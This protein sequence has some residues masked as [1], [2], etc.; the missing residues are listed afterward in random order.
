M[1]RVCV[2]SVRLELVAQHPHVVTPI[3]LAFD[4]RGRLLV[5]ES[6]THQRPEDYSGP[7]SDRIRMLEN[8]LANGQEPRWSTW[9]A[10]FQQAMNL[11]PRSQDEVLLV[12]RRDVLWIADFDRDGRQDPPQQVLRLETEAEYPHNGLSGITQTDRGELWIGLGENFGFPYRLVGSDGTTCQGRGG[13]GTIFTC[14]PRGERL[15]RF[16]TGFWNPFGLTTNPQGQL[17]AVDNDPDAS[18]PCRL[19]HVVATGDYGHRYEYGRSG[20]HPLQAWNGELPGTLPMVCGTGEAPSAVVAHRGWLWVA[21][22]GDHR[23]ERYRL[24][25]RGASYSAALETV[26]QG[27]HNFRPTG[28]TVGP[29][30]SIFFGDWVSA[31]YP[32]H[33]KGRIWR[34]TVPAEPIRATGANHSS[35][36]GRESAQAVMIPVRDVFQDQDQIRHL[37]ES[38]DLP[39]SFARAKDPHERSQVLQALRWRGPAETPP[40]DLLRAALGDDDPS[41]R[42]LAVRWI[43]DERILPLRQD[44]AQLLDGSMPGP[45]YYLAVLAAIDWLAREPTPRHVGIADGLLARELRHPRRSEAARALALSLLAPDHPFLSTDRLKAYFA[46]DSPAIRREAVRAAAMRSDGPTLDLLAER[47]RDPHEDV[48]IR[49]DAIA[50]LAAAPTHF[51]D[52]LHQLA[53]ASDSVIAQEAKRVL[54]QAGLKPTPHESKPAPDDL[55]AWIQLTNTPG[56]AASGRRLFFSPAGTRCC[57]C[58][59]HGRRGGRVGPDLTQIALAQD[60]SRILESILMPGR[61]IAPQY[62][63]WTLVTQDGRAHLGLRLHGGG[64]DQQERYLDTQGR[65]FALACKAIETREPAPGSVMPSG[66]ERILTI[67]D[68]R[69]LLAFLLQPP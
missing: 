63:A 51:A 12:T 67:A 8:P 52:L 64:D 4:R 2:E 21:S 41:I 29:D 54:R 6:H 28:M 43:A 3:G 17:F 1:P 40:L 48:Q 46:S 7:D 22:W 62:Q 20:L 69:D 19:L 61:E 33:G 50:G 25:P 35:P 57:A 36:P 14:G 27:D 66:A 10:G 24:T 16:A 65:E 47:A 60:R 13:V 30:G 15:R 42:L 38:S 11:L 23:I 49:A 58:H 39:H 59:Q 26:V 34:M 53:R 45:R 9:A 5:V 44:V 31:S 32:V 56:N 18:P 55:D 37:T 68:L